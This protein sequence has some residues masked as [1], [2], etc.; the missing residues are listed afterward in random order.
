MPG[1][2]FSVWPAMNIACRRARIGGRPT[3]YRC[4]P[5]CCEQRSLWPI[6]G[7][8]GPQTEA[9]QAGLEAVAQHPE[10]NYYAEETLGGRSYLTAIYADRAI[11][12]CCIECHNQHPQSPRRDFRLNDVMGAL[13]VRVPLEF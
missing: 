6:N 8:Y 5:R 11:L 13:V 12:P 2:S 1:S 9:E 4:P 7:N 3:D 10:T